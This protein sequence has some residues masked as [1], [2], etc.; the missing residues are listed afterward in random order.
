MY[1]AAGVSTLAP[2]AL[3]TSTWTYP[4]ACAGVVKLNELA[5]MPVGM[6]A[7]P[8]MVAVI[9]ATNPLPVTVTT[10]PPVTGPADGVTALITGRLSYVYVSAGV[11]AVAPPGVVT[12]TPTVPVPGGLVTVTVVALTTASP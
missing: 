1:P 2:A 10:W 4:A 7:A 6:T 5:V 12:V 11:S 8:P 9:P 3:V